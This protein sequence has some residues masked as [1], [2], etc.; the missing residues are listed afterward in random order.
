MIIAFPLEVEKK[1]NAIAAQK[2]LAPEAYLVLL[3]QKDL[4][5]QI[6]FEQPNGESAPAGNGNSE[7]AVTARERLVGAC[8]PGIQLPPGVSGQD[9]MDAL[10]SDRADGDDPDALTKAILK[11]TDRT[12]EERMAI[13]EELMNVIPAPLPIPAGKTI[14]DQIPRIRGNETEAQVFEAL[15]RL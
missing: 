11:F 5:M 15:E 9:V 8:N 6:A 13:R 2:G 7:E 12:P 3:V 10:K 14:F 4:E 1:V